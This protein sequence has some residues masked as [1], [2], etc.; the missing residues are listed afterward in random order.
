M[1]LHAHACAQPP[2]RAARGILSFSF[3]KAT[4][5]AMPTGRPNLIQTPQVAWQTERDEATGSATRRHVLAILWTAFAACLVTRCWYVFYNGPLDHLFSDP[6]RHVRNGWLFF[7]PDFLGSMDPFAYQL[8]LRA[9][10]WFDRGTGYVI[11]AA[12]AMLSM[13][14][15]AFWLKALREVLP[16]AWALMAAIAIGLMPSLFLIY[17]YFMT[18]TLLLTLSACGFWLTLR[19]MRTRDAPTLAGAALVWTVA[20]Y[21]RLV[22]LPLAALCFLAIALSLTWP[23]RAALAA[24]TCACFGVMAIP[25]C[26][27]SNTNLHFCAPFGLGY[28]NTIYRASDARTMELIV[29]GQGE[30]EF[31]SPS[32]ISRPLAPFSDWTSARTATRATRIDLKN[33]REDWE[34]TLRAYRQHG[35][36]L[37]WLDD[38]IENAIMLAF[39]PSWPDNNL[40]Y[41]WGWLSF[42]NRW[43]WLPLLVAVGVL[44]AKVRPTVREGLVPFCGLALVALLLVQTNGIMEGRY[45]KPAE[46]LLVAGAFVLAHR[47]RRNAIKGRDVDCAER[48]T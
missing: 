14:L 38:K 4:R 16:V 23:K 31:T 3:P 46:P 37:P 29:V 47:L 34:K 24:A 28:F 19:A 39:D 11:L 45:R 26:W 17:S 8:W 43:L 32:M 2:R 6:Y 41:A 15:P 13:A 36:S 5:I 20:S 7:S 33:G 35:P 1:V 9:L 42:W 10:Q 48:R 12:T 30:W 18:E 44:M 25:A 27:H 21:T 22:A 40:A